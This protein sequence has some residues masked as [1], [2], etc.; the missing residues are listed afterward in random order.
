MMLL[1][2]VTI[3]LPEA[4]ITASSAS[5]QVGKDLVEASLT[6]AASDG[7]TFRKIVLPLMAPG[8]ASGWALIFVMVAGEVTASALLAGV[9][10]PVIGFV[11]LDAWQAG[12]FGDLAALAS[13]FAILNLIVVT[14]AVWFVRAKYSAR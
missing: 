1:A 3:Y 6:S 7:R 5:I 8:L 13:A 10:T 11:I 9:G 2:Y 12:T 14:S 4:Y